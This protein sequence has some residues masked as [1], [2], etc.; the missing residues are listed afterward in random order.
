MKAVVD[1]DSKT[2]KKHSTKFEDGSK[3]TYK[4]KSG[5]RLKVKRVSNNPKTDGPRMKAKAK[6]AGPLRM[7]HK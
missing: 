3:I 5:G 1:G 7:G 4:H 2:P 6:R